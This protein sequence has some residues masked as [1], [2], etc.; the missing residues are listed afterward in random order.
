MSWRNPRSTLIVCAAL[1][2]AGVLLLVLLLSVVLGLSL[3]SQLGWVAL[4]ALVYLVL[5][6]LFGSYT[7][8]R[9]RRLSLLSVIQR[10]LITCLGTFVAVAVA[11]VLA[12]PPVLI[13]LVHRSTQ[14]QLLLPLLLWSL[15]IRALLRRGVL[16]PQQSQFLLLG[17]DSEVQPVIEAWNRTPPRLPLQRLALENALAVRTPC[18]LAVPASLRQDPRKR[19]FLEQ[20]ENRDPRELSL[21]SPLT[22]LERQLERLPPELLPDSW[23]NYDELPWNNLFSLQRQLKRVADVMVAL[24][25]LLLMSPFILLAA[26]LIWLEDRG[27]VFYRQYRTGWLGRRFLVLKLRTMGVASSDAPPRWTEPGDPRI[28][29]IGIWLRRLRL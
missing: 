23:L 9:W 12:N 20:L 13:W 3:S 14:G 6:W 21:T 29:R 8:L 27:P 11:R 19:E 7:V 25:L 17:A 28:T 5:G 22:L 10:L 26:A 15:L 4:M 24:V 2:L 18:V 1:D 16:L